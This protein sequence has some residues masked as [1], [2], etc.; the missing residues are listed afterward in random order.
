M[1]TT[2][3]ARCFPAPERAAA[4]RI[5]LRDHSLAPSP[6]GGWPMAAMAGGLGVRLVKRDSYSFNADAPEPGPGDIGRALG[7]IG[8]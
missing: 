1:N 4:L 3:H 5:A 7:L 2:P 8:G 6:N